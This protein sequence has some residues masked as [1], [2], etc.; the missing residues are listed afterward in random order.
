[1]SQQERPHI[2]WISCTTFFLIL[3]A[4]GCVELKTAYIPPNALPEEWIEI[5]SL[6]NTGIEFFGL[7]KWSSIY[8]EVQDNTDASLTVTTINTLALTDEDELIDHVNATVY[9][10]FKDRY[11]LTSVIEDSRDLLKKHTSKYVIYSGEN[12]SLSGSV[13][14]IGEVWNCGITGV[15]IICLGF[16]FA[17]YNSSTLINSSTP[18]STIVGDPVGSI[19]GHVNESGLIYNVRCHQ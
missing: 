10:I 2:I 17:S 16:V 4:T 14:I 18:W 11:S 13:R 1:M 8:Y 19:D 15:S 9:S 5:T 3:M 7:E 12:R 6:Q